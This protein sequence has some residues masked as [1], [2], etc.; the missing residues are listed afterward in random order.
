[1]NIVIV[2]VERREERANKQ[3]TDKR[4]NIHILVT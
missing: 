1:M 2:T 3:K 4:I